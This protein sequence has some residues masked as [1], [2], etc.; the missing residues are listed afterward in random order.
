MCEVRAEGYADLQRLFV[1]K[2]PFVWIDHVESVE[3]VATDPSLRGF[4]APTFVDGTQRLPMVNGMQHSYSH[5]WLAD[6]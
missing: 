2:M 3:A 1:E 6:S 5:M 4:A